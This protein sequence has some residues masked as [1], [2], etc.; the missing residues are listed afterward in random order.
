M[1]S[2]LKHMVDHVRGRFAMVKHDR[3]LAEEV[4]CVCVCIQHVG[5]IMMNLQSA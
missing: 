2:L 1:S 3:E 4:L 5:A